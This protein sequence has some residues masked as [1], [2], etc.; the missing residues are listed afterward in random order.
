MNAP[1][2]SVLIVMGVSGCGKSTIG[3]LLAGSLQWNFE[4]ADWFHPAA[5]VEK[6]HQGIPLTD[7]DRGPWLRAVAAAIDK[8]RAG[9]AP[10]VIA[11]SALKRRYRDVLIGDRADVRL[12]Y[13]KG[14]EELISRRIAT[15]HEHFMPPSLLHS[16]FVALE[17]PGPDENPITVSVEPAPREIVA[18]IL[19]ALKAGSKTGPAE[20]SS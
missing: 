19:A 20:S 6:M 9:G 4:D 11:C 12:V 3:T 13:L 17:E 2:P 14:S 18:Q 8:M 10:G 7:E 5:N 16:Q 1:W 15:R